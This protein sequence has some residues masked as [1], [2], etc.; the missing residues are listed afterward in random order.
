MLQLPVYPLQ[1]L[2][3]ASS[4]SLLNCLSY[5]VNLSP[6]TVLGISC[7]TAL[8]TLIWRLNVTILLTTDI[9]TECHDGEVRLNYVQYGRVELCINNTWG[10]ICYDFWDKQDAS[11]L[12]KQ[13]GYSPYG[14]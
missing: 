10:T 4:V 5:S 1:F 8:R 3:Y 6:S 12:C 14:M 11:V 2:C 7:T 9:H 13:L